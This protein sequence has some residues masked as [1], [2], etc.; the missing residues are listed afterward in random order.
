MRCCCCTFDSRLSSS[1]AVGVE[2]LCRAEALSSIS[3]HTSD[4]DCEIFLQVPGEGSSVEDSCV[5]VDG[6][7]IGDTGDDIDIGVLIFGY[8]LVL[9]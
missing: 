5:E 9:W 6:V 4:P 2:A 1:S 7:N 8:C 3:D